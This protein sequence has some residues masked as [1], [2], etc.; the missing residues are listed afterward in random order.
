MKLIFDL[1]LS[2]QSVLGIIKD[3]ERRKIPSPTGKEKWCKR[4]I[5]VML[6]NEKYTGDVRLLKS[7]ESETKY[8]STDNNPAMI[9]KKIFE[10][11][12]IEK[13]KRSNV[14]RI[15]SGKQRKDRKYSSKMKL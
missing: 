9:S 1:Y 11:V 10:A 4:T 2:G 5:D 8:L 13:R 12:Q 3:L 7:R 14:I 15:E 6:S